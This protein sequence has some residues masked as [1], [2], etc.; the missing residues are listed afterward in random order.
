MGDLIFKRQ[1]KSFRL[2]TK[3]SFVAVKS[4][5]LLFLC[6]DTWQTKVQGSHF[7]GGLTII[8]ES[9]QRYCQPLGSSGG[10]LEITTITREEMKRKGKIRTYLKRRRVREPIQ[11]LPYSFRSDGSDVWPSSSTLALKGVVTLDFGSH[12]LGNTSMCIDDEVWWT[13]LCIWN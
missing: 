3:G 6:H 5:V 12:S 7:L 9:T 10:E 11:H 1:K 4:Q 13:D 8:T 2:L